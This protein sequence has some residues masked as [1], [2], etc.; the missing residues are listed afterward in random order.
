MKTSELH[1]VTFPKVLYKY[2]MYEINFFLHNFVII[3]ADMG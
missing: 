3:N 1:F 2:D